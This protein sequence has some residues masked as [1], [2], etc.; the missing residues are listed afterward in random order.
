MATV[1][2]ARDLRHERLVALK[3]MHPELA[4]TLGRERFLREIRVAAGFSHPHIVPLHDSGSADGMLFYVMPFVEGESLRARLARDGTLPIP[5]VMTFARQVAD[6]VAYA[7]DRGVVHRDLKP[8]NVLIDSSG[9]ALV[10]DFGVALAA[11]RA[12]DEHLTRTG[13]SLGTPAYMS[14]E[15]LATWW[16]RAATSGPWGASCTRCSPESCRRAA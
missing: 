7:H 10:T 6:A 14:P 16:T 3:V 4:V 1:H 11:H 9:H 15:Q 5:D 12:G 2:L 8:D 13:V